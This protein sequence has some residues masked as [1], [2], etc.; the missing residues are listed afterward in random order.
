MPAAGP[1]GL[2]LVAAAR[3]PGQEVAGDHSVVVGSTPRLRVLS[4]LGL[5]QHHR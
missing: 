4:Y 1:P 3:P 5:E 2:A